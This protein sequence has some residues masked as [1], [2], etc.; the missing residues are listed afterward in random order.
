MVRGTHLFAR[1]GIPFDGKQ[2][3]GACLNMGQIKRILLFVLLTSM[4]FSTGCSPFLENNMIEEIAP[5][6]FWYIHEGEEGQIKMSTLMPPLIKEKKRPITL[7]AHMIKQGG[8]DFNFNYY[9]E[10]KAGQIRMMFIEESLA[11]KGIMPLIHTIFLDPDVSQ[12]IYLVIVKGNFQ[13]YVKNQV[14]EQEN[15]DYFLYLMFKHYEKNNQ[16]EMTIVNLHQ[17]M[18]LLYSPFS[19]PILPVFNA[20]QEHFTYEGTAIFNHDKLKTT[21]KNIDD[22]IVQLIGNDH[23][24]KF[25]PIPKLSIV[26]G[27]VRSDVQMEWTR[28]YSSLSI[29]VDLNARIREYRGNK[30]LFDENELADLSNEIEAYL[31]NHTTE[32]IQKLQKWKVD[33]FQIGT[34]TLSPF[35]KPLSED[36]WLR[37]F[38]RMEVDIDYNL[39]IQPLTDKEK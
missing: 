2:I 8:K 35:A 23:F 6:T 36:Q 30:G 1:S 29:R 17:F 19:D 14:R 7:Q 37:Y 31:E 4:M 26:L 32:L 13:D 28:K 20:D 5:I 33:P 34:L 9:R 11:K 10:I 21:V 22:Q 39:H 38:E 27:Q 25:L 16:G 15:L 3:K 18:K 24:L 12:R